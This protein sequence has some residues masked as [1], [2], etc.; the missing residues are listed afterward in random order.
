M[1]EARELKNEE[2]KNNLVKDIKWSKKDFRI[3][4]IKRISRK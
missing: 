4:Q 2:K 1:Q 3:K